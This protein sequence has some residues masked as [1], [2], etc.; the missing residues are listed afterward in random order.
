[1]SNTRQ[2]T[3]GYAAASSADLVVELSG[4]DIGNCVVSRWATPTDFSYEG[5][6]AVYESHRPAGGYVGVWFQIVF[7]VSEHDTSGV[8]TVEQEQWVLDVLDEI[9]ARDPGATVYL[10][11]LNE[12]ELGHVCTRTGLNGDVLAGVLAGQVADA[13][14]Y[15]L[16]VSGPVLGP[17][18][19][20][21][22][23]DGCHLNDT[24]IGLVGGQM[25]A[26]FD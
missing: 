14:A 25:V 24:G 17:L 6:W 13:D 5:C 4:T 9:A 16:I 26:Y 23:S 3:Q 7:H 21:H 20:N 10:S 12:Y 22:L 8:P 15:D 2:A 11:G 19:S 18:P 1:M